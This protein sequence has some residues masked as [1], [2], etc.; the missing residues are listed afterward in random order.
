MSQTPS[1]GSAYFQR[2]RR[3][4]AGQGKTRAES[5]RVSQAQN[6][7]N[8]KEVEVLTQ[9]KE[10]RDILEEQINMGLQEHRRDKSRLF[11]SSVTA[12]MEVG[13]SVLLMGV[14]YTLFHA[15]ISDSAMK[16]ALGVAYPIGFLFVVIGRSELFTEHTNVAILPV[17][18]RRVG[19]I[20]LGRIWGIIYTG[21]LIGGYMIGGIIIAI[22]PRMGIVT[23]SALEH[24][25]AKMIPYDWYIILGSG[26]L[27]GWM[28]GLL[29]WLVTASRE[30]ISQIFI[31]ILVTSVIGIGGLHHSI[32]GSIEVFTAMLIYDK[33]NL[34]EYLHFQ[35]WTT[36]GNIL[37]GAVFVA[38]FHY[39]Q[40]REP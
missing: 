29:S 7:P 28:M 9:S 32:V 25:G 19:L 11:L 5:A 21:N 14:L 40:S 6:K 24:L 4:G 36:I 34:P 3:N 33:I 16:L 27:A 39:G 35:V 10:S 38:L 15:S 31:V 17:L 30:T 26:L 22:A 12:G 23:L 1:R 18:D 20:S 8:R 13:F 2:P 37:G